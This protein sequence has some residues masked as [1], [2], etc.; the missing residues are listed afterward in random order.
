MLYI[1]ISSYH[2][3]YVRVSGMVLTICANS[4]NVPYNNKAAG[5]CLLVFGVIFA[6]SYVVW[7]N[8]RR[9]PAGES[10][11]DGKKGKDNPAYGSSNSNGRKA[12]QTVINIPAPEGSSAPAIQIQAPSTKGK[13]VQFKNTQNANYLTADKNST[14]TASPVIDLK[15]EHTGRTKRNLS[16]ENLNGFSTMV[17]VHSEPKPGPSGTG[18]N[19]NGSIY[20]IPTIIHEDDDDDDF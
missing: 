7:K 17:E 14:V 6:F 12:A 15:R 13:K 19:K 3:C 1:C 4:D 16:E 11:C 8:F 20:T 10:T 18:S 9:N 5:P 2:T